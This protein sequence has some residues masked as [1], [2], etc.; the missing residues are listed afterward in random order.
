MTRTGASLVKRR[1]EFD[2]KCNLE[3][4]N[5]KKHSNEGIKI[6]VVNLTNSPKVT[7]K[8]TVQARIQTENVNVTKLLPDD[9]TKL[10]DDTPIGP[11]LPD[12]TSQMHKLQSLKIRSTGRQYNCHDCAFEGN[13]SKNLLRH[14]KESGHKNVSDLSERCYTCDEKLADYD[15]LMQ[16]RREKHPATINVC[17]FYRENR[18][19][20]G[21]NCWFKHESQ[22]VPQSNTP[23]VNSQ[24]QINFQSPRDQVPPDQLSQL[25]V[26]VKDLQH[27]VLSTMQSK[28]DKMR[29]SSPGL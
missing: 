4:H 9:T 27:L 13:S 1:K 18:C 22:S 19:N 29:K 6:P 23:Q 15:H 21:T 10:P 8:N 7:S 14:S 16:H 26:L 25:C 2:S 3:K 12:D 17:R 20:F 5:E 24:N 11:K 28:E